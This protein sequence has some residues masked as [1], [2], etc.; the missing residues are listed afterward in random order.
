MRLSEVQRRFSDMM[1]DHP[2]VVENPPEDLAVVFE[3]GDIALSHRLKV[4]RNNIVGSLTD[5]MLESFPVI[6]ALVGKE[7]LEGM[8]RSF[9]LENPPARGCLTFYGDG[10]AEFIEGFAPAASLPYLP[11]I[12]RLE[13]A[14]NDAYYARDDAALTAEDL[15]CIAAEDL[16]SVVVPLRHAVQLLQSP[17]PVH[18]I[19]GFALSGN[20]DTSLDIDTGGVKLLIDRAEMDSRIVVLDDAEFSVLCALKNQVALGEAVE[21]AMEHFP[22]FDFQEFLQKHLTLETFAAIESNVAV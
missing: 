15:G 4:Y 11:D 10:F 22:D 14:M 18:D 7:F 20:Q 12:A 8:A 2:D 13:I 21:G 6:E 5:V 9:V 17:Y 1:L 19:R 16:A 3:A